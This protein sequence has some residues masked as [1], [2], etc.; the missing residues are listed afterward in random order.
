M[1]K[2]FALIACLAVASPALATTT[3]TLNSALG[4]QAT[5]VCTTGT[6]AAPTGNA[7]ISL[8]YVSGVAVHIESEVALSAGTLQAYVLNPLS[9]KWNRAGELDLVVPAGVT[10]WAWTGLRVF[11]RFSRLA[12]VPVGIGQ[13]S[14]IF[15][16]GG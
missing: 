5:A 1:K 7:G 8:A 4:G 2:S 13:P 14:T 11:A 10:G 6:E 9:G 16:L 12:Y 3:W 15:V